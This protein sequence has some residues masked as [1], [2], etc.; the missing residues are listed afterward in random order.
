MKSLKKFVK[1]FKSR[2]GFAVVLSSLF[3][4]FSGLLTSIFVVRWLTPDTL[5]EITFS[6]ALLSIGAIFAGLGSN[7][8]LLRYGPLLNSYSEKFGMF[9]FTIKNGVKLTIIIFVLVVAIS[10]VLPTNIHNAQVY[11]IILAIGLFTNF[12]FESLLAY[13]RV[14]NKNKLYSKA[15]TYASLFLACLTC[16]FAYFFSGIGYTAAIVIAPFLSFLIYKKHIYRKRDEGRIFNINVKE[17]YKYGIYTGFGVVA[18]QLVI[19]SGSIIAV[20]LG[21][22]NEDVAMFKVATIIPFNLMFLPSL[23]M[24]TDFVHFSKN[25]KNGKILSEYYYNYLKTILTISIIP[26]AI[27]ISFNKEILVLLYGEEYS[28]VASMSLYLN[29]AIFFSF[30]LRIPLGNILSAVGKANWNV[31][32]S[33]IW[34]LLFIPLT[35]ILFNYMGIEGVALSIS[36]VI[37]AS[38]FISLILFYNYLKLLER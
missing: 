28:D 1:D 29:G 34:L 33:F 37:I 9:Q 12:L 30:L 38:G 14:I 26:F 3:L 16:L 13:F 18:N 22:T 23:I 7:W 32:H 4:K 19:S 35:A 24:T 15:N 27:L 5:G 17:F 31:V 10:F 20:V 8:S 21:A 36:I 6:V 25:H 11:I 2:D